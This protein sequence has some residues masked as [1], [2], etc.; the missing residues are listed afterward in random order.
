MHFF[1][2]YVRGGMCKHQNYDL[3]SHT[4]TLTAQSS[5]HCYYL[6]CWCSRVVESVPRQGWSPSSAHS[7]GGR[8]KA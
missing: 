8:R 5:K 6:S 7:G 4:V 2:L 1:V 3:H